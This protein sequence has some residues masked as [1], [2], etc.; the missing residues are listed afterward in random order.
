[1]RARPS[2][3][4]LMESELALSSCA[5]QR[6]L[7]PELSST[8]LCRRSRTRRTGLLAIAAS[9]LHTRT[10]PRELFQ[11]DARNERALAYLNDSDLP[12]LNQLIELTKRNREK[13]RSV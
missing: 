13:T 8:I 3:P 4:W 12:A 7:Q 11:F 6:A 1:M 9:V 5:G 10:A 2:S